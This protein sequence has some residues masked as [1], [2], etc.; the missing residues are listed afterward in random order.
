M[1]NK[2]IG[3][4]A[5]LFFLSALVSC[6]NKMTGRILFELDG[7][8]FPSDFGT[9]SLEGESGTP[10][11]TEIPDPVKSGYYF[12][13]WREKSKDGSY[14]VINKRT[15]KDGKA[16]Y[17]YPYVTDT[18]YAYFEPLSTITFDLTQG[19][20]LMGLVA[21]KVDGSSFHDNKL[22]GYASKKLLS[23]D[24]LPTVEKIS[25]DSHLTF[26]GWYSEYPLV[27]VDDENGQ[28]HY[29]LDKTGEAGEYMFERSFGTDNMCF[30]IS[31][32]N[33]FTLYAKWIEDPTVTIHYNL[34]GVED[35]V[36]Q[37]RD[38]VS[39]KIIS[40]IY[41]KT[42]MDFNALDVERFYNQDRTK[43]FNGLY[44]DN[45]LKSRFSL[46]SEI[47][48]DNV[49]IYL[50]WDD[51]IS[52]TI[53]YQDGTV[54]GK[55]SDTYPDTYYAGDVLGETFYKEH[56]PSAIN[57]TFLGY[58][59]EGE[60]FNV[61]RDALP[62]HDVTLQ[63]FYSD[64][65]SL[66]L[67]YDYPI[68]YSGT[69]LSTATSYYEKGADI[70]EILHDFRNRITDES[71][72]ASRFYQLSEGKKVDFTGDKM[73]S[74]DLELYL[75]LVY[76]PKITIQSYYNPSGAYVS[77]TGVN[78]SFYLSIGE[79]LTESG[80]NSYADKITVDG[81]DYLFDSFYADESFTE[82][83]LFPLSLLPSREAKVERTLYRKMTKAVTVTFVEKT[84]SETIG[85]VSALPGTSFASS[86][87]ILSLLGTYD[88]LT[89]VSGGSEKTL[90]QIPD[91]N[92]TVFVYR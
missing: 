37:G 78:P 57:K 9:T 56:I 25:K 79:T 1:K 34:D 73:S 24:Y 58:Q 29:S 77:M 32:D 76:L 55:H 72:A 35:S 39:D 5:S 22:N 85:T 59:L 28:K 13:G 69:I 82:K 60:Q 53:D 21:P 83:V 40:E 27:G 74:N 67:R 50:G 61:I 2:C 80:M 36:F 75:E 63:A 65:P 91:V 62:S 15:Y 81:V 31:D 19:E 70:T 14:R 89:I 11:L 68:G 88:H 52:V 12:V 7:G 20:G 33:N 90:N 48:D 49:D 43:R 47:G 16:Y 3:I 30:P 45:E 51:R 64:Y 87:E 10:I 18:F 86:K 38:N 8:S 71:I 41:S 54:G 92:A 17:F 23:T 6:G 66:T 84:T 44:L 4:T 42:G 26:D 46:D